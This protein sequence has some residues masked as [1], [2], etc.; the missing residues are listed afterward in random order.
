MRE[1]LPAAFRLKEE[2]NPMRKSPSFRDLKTL[3]AYLDGEL[4][5]AARKKMEDRLARDPNLRAALDDLRATRAVL[6]KAPQRRA[7]KNFTLSPKQVAQ[8]PPM[9]RMGLS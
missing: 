3:F 4:G 2:N 7:P 1:L 8:R 6:R 9:P 5:A